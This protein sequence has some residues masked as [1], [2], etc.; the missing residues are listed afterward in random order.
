MFS[1]SRTF[2]RASRS[3]SLLTPMMAKGWFLYFSTSDRSCGYMARQ[4]PHQLPQKS[5]RTTFPR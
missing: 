1:F 2:L 5:S 3:V 4:G